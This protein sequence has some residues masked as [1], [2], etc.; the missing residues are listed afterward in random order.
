MLKLRLVWVAASLFLPA[1]VL[2]QAPEGAEHDFQLELQAQN[3]YFF[4]EGLYPG[5]RRNYLSFAVTPEYSLEWAQGR[6]LIKLVGFGRLDQFDQ[7]RTHVDLRELYY[8]KVKKNWEISLGFKKIFWGVTESAHLVDIINQTDQVESFDGEQK[9]GQPMVHFSYLSNW[10]TWD[11]FYLPY[12]RKRQFPSQRGRLRFPDVIEREDF[13]IDSEI[14]EWHPGAAMRWSHYFGPIDIGVSYYYGV[15]R[16]P[17]FI[18]LASESPQLIYPIIH[19]SGLDL[20]ATTGP[21]LWKLET[22]YRYADE[23]DF[24][25]LA[26]GFEYTF[27]NIAASG[28]DLG[29]L[30]EY[31]YDSRDELAINNL[32]NDVFTGLRLAF[33]DV[34][35]TEFLAGGTFDLEGSSR[36]FSVE[37][38]RRF[39]NVWKG[40]LEARLF[41]R[42]KTDELAFFL[43]NDSFLQFTL[44]RYF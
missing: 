4:K 36:F 22:I 12:A 13:V 35:S 28:L 40:E 33:N 14:E 32:A 30:A 15:G 37:S 8:Q 26:A 29:I 18:G 7:N 23:Q 25:S 9:L 11:F 42:V 3:R 31:L 39:G 38:S 24:V 44:F 17:L 2:G 41:H 6:N 10:G 19:Q 27:G 5:Q 20:Q 43:R 16:E 34:S 21:L 1:L